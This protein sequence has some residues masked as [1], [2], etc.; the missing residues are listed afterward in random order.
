MIDNEPCRDWKHPAIFPMKAWQIDSA[1]QMQCLEA[2]GN[3]PT[4]A[5]LQRDLP[6][7]VAQDW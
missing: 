1:L 2:L 7:F 4:N 6:A 3:A 5:E